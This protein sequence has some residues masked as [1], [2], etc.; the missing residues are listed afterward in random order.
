[1]RRLFTG[2]CSLL[3]CLSLIALDPGEA[4]AQAASYPDRTITVVVPFLAGGVTDLAARAVAEAMEKHLKQPVVVVNKPGGRATVGGFAVVSAKPDG[5]TLGFFPVTT[6]MP[7]VF[8]YFYEAPYA[9][10]DFKPIAGVAATALSFVVPI[11]AP[12]NSLA[13]VVEFARKN[14]G[15]KVGTPG[16]QTLPHLLL[17]QMA[18][19]N[20]VSLVDVPFAGDG[21]TLPALLGGHVPVAAIDYSAMKSLVDA[22]KLKVLAVS[23]EKRVDFAPDIPS[24]A[25]LGYKLPYVSVVGLFG[26]KELPDELA[27]KIDELVGKISEE[28]GFRAKMKTLSIQPAYAGSAGYRALLS[29]YKDNLQALFKEEGWVK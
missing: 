5:Y 23:T 8:S 25:E 7:E 2:L 22:K 14:P 1:M 18:K 10:K 16:K 12:W 26:P 13:D 17:M 27:K 24:M 4:R 29:R 15:V 19:K 6:V 9:S 21:A 3:V 28:Q 11:D 20:N